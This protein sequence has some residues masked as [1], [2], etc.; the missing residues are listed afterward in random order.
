MKRCRKLLL[1]LLFLPLPLVVLLVPVAAALLIY[2]FLWEG[3]HPAVTY[4][5]YFLSAYALT[6]VCVRAPALWRR[7]ARFRDTN[8]YILHYRGD[9]RLRVG[10]SLT[11]TLAGNLFYALLQ[12]GLGLIHHSIWFYALTGY[13]ALLALMRAFLLRAVRSGEPG[14][15][16]PR[17]YR[18]YGRCGLLL[19]PMNLTLAVVVTFM[20]WQNRG[21]S[22]HPIAT[23][24][25][26]A[27]TFFSLTMAIVQMVRYRKYR[28]PVL[29][30]SKSIS[31]VAALVSLLNLETAMLTAFGTQEEALFR[32]IMT[33]ATGGAVCIAVLAIALW[34]LRRAHKELHPSKGDPHHGRK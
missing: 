25:L 29:S 6:L 27:Y 15:D 3:V 32:Q 30:A 7:V 16:L 1:D 2:V 8:P 26:A 12:L 4:G 13:Y 21:F 17:E 24:A 11:G 31:L 28:S 22:Y 33:A 20:V 5:A 19:V 10:L 18:L 9:P 23:I 14:A 34:M